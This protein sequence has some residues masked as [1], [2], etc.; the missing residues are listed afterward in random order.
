MALDLDSGFVYVIGPVDRRE[1]YLVKVGWSKNVVRR[2]RSLQIGSPVP[3]EILCILQWHDPRM[4]TEIHDE[5]AEF[6]RHGEWFELGQDPAG[7][8]KAAMAKVK[9][10]HGRARWAGMA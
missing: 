3:L 7:T 2:K 6:R 4:E 1:P 5:L 10:E 9:A 8:V